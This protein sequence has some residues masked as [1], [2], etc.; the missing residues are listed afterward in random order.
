MTRNFNRGNVVHC[1]EKML[2]SVSISAEV[3][4]CG[5]IGYNMWQHS[6]LLKRK[7]LSFSPDLIILGLFEDDLMESIPKYSESNRYEGGHPFQKKRVWGI[8]ENFSLLNILKNANTLFEYKNRYR[9][10]HAY[11]KGIEERRIGRE[12]YPYTGGIEL[13]A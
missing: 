6:E 5:V 7:V 13:G 2:K 12:T 11:L 4:N 3:I 10:G 8:A 1:V 9:R